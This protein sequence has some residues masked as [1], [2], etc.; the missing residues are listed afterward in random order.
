MKNKAIWNEIHKMEAVLKSNT[1][2]LQASQR[3]NVSANATNPT[4]REAIEDYKSLKENVLGIANFSYQHSKP[5]VAYQ[6]AEI[7]I[8]KDNS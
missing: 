1:V 7:R 4:A 5:K 8:P 3:S 2:K 6:Y